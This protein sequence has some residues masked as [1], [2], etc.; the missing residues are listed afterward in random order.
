MQQLIFVVVVVVASQQPC[1]MYSVVFMC[2]LVLPSWGWT[3][4]FLMDCTFAP[5][6]LGRIIV[7]RIWI[8][9]LLMAILLADNVCDILLWLLY[10]CWIFWGW[11]VSFLMKLNA[12]LF[13][14][15]DLLSIDVSISALVLCDADLC[16]LARDGTGF[17]LGWQVTGR[18]VCLIVRSSAKVLVGI[19]NRVQVR[20]VTVARHLQSV[21]LAQCTTPGFGSVTA[22]KGRCLVHPPVRTIGQL[23][24]VL[25]ISHWVKWCGILSY[26]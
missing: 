24:V 11:N 15:N 4:P 25:Q 3:Y 13:R 19:S 5:P 1:L 7:W 17:L 20:I 22:F 14:A 6:T 9:F 8:F 12:Y 2:V 23:A 18:S 16:R 21:R 10:S 26:G